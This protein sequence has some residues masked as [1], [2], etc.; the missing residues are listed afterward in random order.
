LKLFD[1]KAIEFITI[2]PTAMEPILIKSL[3]D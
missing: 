3:R 2:P 1:P